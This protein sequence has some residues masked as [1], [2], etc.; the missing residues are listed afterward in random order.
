[1]GLPFDSFDPRHVADLEETCTDKLKHIAY[2]E[3]V[4]LGQAVHTAY[5]SVERCLIEYRG[6]G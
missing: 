6:M 4:N 3:V 1:M 5:H 2:R